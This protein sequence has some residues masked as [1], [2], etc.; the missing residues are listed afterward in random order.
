MSGYIALEADTQATLAQSVHSLGQ[1]FKS[2]SMLSLVTHTRQR[3]DKG[4]DRSM[5]DTCPACDT[6]LTTSSSSD[7][8]E[9]LQDVTHTIATT[10]RP[11]SP[12]LATTLPS[13]SLST[14]PSTSM[15]PPILPPLLLGASLEVDLGNPG[16]DCD[17][18]FKMLHSA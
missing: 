10:E 1:R 15:Y 2:R 11:E 13:A 3:K 17:G 14:Q 18:M 4:L 7:A 8:Q 9:V 6:S 16:Q 12:L 5:D